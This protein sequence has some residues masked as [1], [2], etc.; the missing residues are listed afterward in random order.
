MTNPVEQQVYRW[1]R[2]GL[3]LFTAAATIALIVAVFLFML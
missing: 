1:P 3:L 2:R